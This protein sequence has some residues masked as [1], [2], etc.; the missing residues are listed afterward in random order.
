MQ[1]CLRTV[2]ERH[3]SGIE[4]A[5]RKMLK[6]RPW[7]TMGNFM[8]TSFIHFSPCFL[9]AS[10]RLSLALSEARPRNPSQPPKRGE[11]HKNIQFFTPSLQDFVKGLEI[12][13]HTIENLSDQ[14]TCNLL[15][16]P[17]KNLRNLQEGDVVDCVKTQGISYEVVG[18]KC[19][20][21]YHL[22]YMM[23]SQCMSYKKYA[24]VHMDW[25]LKINK[26]SKYG[27]CCCIPKWHPPPSHRVMW[28]D[29][30]HPSATIALLHVGPWRVIDVVSC[31]DSD[32]VG[33]A[34][35]VGKLCGTFASENAAF[36]WPLSRW[37]ETWRY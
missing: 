19:L 31:L 37:R 22:T 36:Q 1:I 26:I 27:S 3:A 20:R 30:V 9:F 6:H 28:P 16:P 24:Y 15:S 4:T 17:K 13:H 18:S 14:S 33:V 25:H 2:D 12:F 5:F 10:F 8:V 34:V 23:I 32:R 21:R 7:V 35:P 29:P 11:W